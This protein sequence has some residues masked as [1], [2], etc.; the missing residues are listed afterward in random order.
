LAVWPVSDTAV[1]SLVVVVLLVFLPADAPPVTRLPKPPLEI[2][3]A[4]WPMPSPPA[5]PPPAAPVAD[6]PES[7]LEPVTV[8]VAVDWASP[9]EALAVAEVLLVDAKVPTPIFPERAV[10]APVD[11]LP[12]KAAVALPLVAAASPVATWPV[13]TACAPIAVAVELPE[14]APLAASTLPTVPVA[15]LLPVWPTALA[16]PL[17]LAAVPRSVTELFVR[18]VAVMLLLLPASLAPPVSRAPPPLL[19][20]V[21]VSV[22]MPLPVA[23]PEPASATLRA[24]PVTV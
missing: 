16:P 23:A 22:V 12:P 21:P 15:A 5:S 18:T 3:V 4:L 1:V 17:V 9:V 11:A 6:E 14:F 10:A 19:A 2:V 8:C 20:I 13:E 24:E 7:R